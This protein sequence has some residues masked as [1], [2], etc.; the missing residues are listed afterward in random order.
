MLIAAGQI[1]GV[2]DLAG[3]YPDLRLT[4]DHLGVGHQ[5]RRDGEPRVAAVVGPDGD[6]GVA[7]EAAEHAATQLAALAR[8]GVPGADPASWYGMREVS[9]SEPMWDDNGHVVTLSPSTLQMLSDCPLRW[10]LE[11]E[12][13]LDD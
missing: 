1:S 11:L 2:D 4:I 5:G 10:L 13:E 3:R 7:Y 9:S 6:P 12:D 8:A